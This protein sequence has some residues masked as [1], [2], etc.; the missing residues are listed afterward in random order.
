MTG[1]TPSNADPPSAAMLAWVVA[2]VGLCLL[3]APAVRRLLGRERVWR[4]VRRVGGAS[5][6]L[7]LWHTLPVLVVATVFYLPRIAPDPAF[8]SG[9]WWALRVPWL[10]VLGVVLVGVLVVL[11]PLERWQARLYERTRPRFDV[12]RARPP[13]LGLPTSVAA[14]TY[15]ATRDFAPDGRVPVPAALALD[16]GTTLMMTTRL[17]GREEPDDAMGPLRETV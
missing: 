13:W 6:S 9:A 3:A 17:A 15:F 4:A 12:R 8:G 16:L 5:M 1:Q 10:L 14:L 7:Y 2:Q 11:R